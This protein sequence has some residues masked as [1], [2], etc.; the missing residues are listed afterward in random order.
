MTIGKRLKLVRLNCKESQSTF[1]LRFGLSQ[2]TYSP[3]ELDK[4]AIPDY[5]KIHLFNCGI[6]I[7]WL[8]T[9]KGPMYINDTPLM[10]DTYGVDF[11]K[12][13][14]LSGRRLEEIR[15]MKEYSVSEFCEM[16]HITEDEYISYINGAV[17]SNSLIKELNNSLV[18]LYW[19]VYGTG[20]MFVFDTGDLYTNSAGENV[21][22]IENRVKKGSADSVI[23]VPMT[24][25]KVS[26]GYGAEWGSGAFSGELI[27]VPKRIIN[28]YGNV[29]NVA[30]ALVKGDSMNPTLKDGEVV[31]F[32]KGLIDG[33]GIY[34]IAILGE[35]FVKRVSIDMLNNKVTIISDNKNYPVKEYDL[36]REGF[37]VIGKSNLLD[38]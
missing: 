14:V 3:Y 28:K 36:D 23:F 25:L 4:R 5:F 32:N 30:A 27:P 21:T 20:H 9:G 37:E 15:K 26:A 1:A 10:I 18:N 35:L 13:D 38:T 22:D 16:Y 19:L 34:V 2:S 7:N 12:Y 17:P 11:S 31:V 29:V 6:N 8:L 33:D 24:N